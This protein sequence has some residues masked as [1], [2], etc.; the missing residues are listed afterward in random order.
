MPKTPSDELALLEPDQ[1]LTLQPA[2]M[3]KAVIDKGVTAESVGVVERLVALYERMTE[4]DA[5]RQFAVA[6]AKLQADTP[7]VQAVREV[8]NNDGSVRYTYAPYEEIMAKVRPLLLKHGF[9]VTFSSAVIDA[10][11]VQSCTLQHVG[12]HKRTNQ[13]AARIGKGPPGSSEA[14]G[15]GAASTYAKRFAL[16]DAL[17]I[18]VDRDTDARAE[19]GCISFEQAAYLKEMVR[20]TKSDERA[21]LKYAGAADYEHITVDRYDALAREL[22][23]KSQ[24][25]RS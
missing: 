1:P 20:E 24:Q 18:I 17:N 9:T 16:C 10:R 14:Q 12:G 2:Q 7:S 5:E 6:F 8:P 15:D 4:K 11:I 23:K 3:L 22:H 19:A 21:F 13:S 25:P